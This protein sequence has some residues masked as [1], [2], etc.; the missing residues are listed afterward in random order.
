MENDLLF[1]LRA[2]Y[3]QLFFVILHGIYVLMTQL[4]TIILAAVMTWTVESKSSVS[5]EGT[6]PYDIEVAYNNTYSKGTVRG[7]DDAV[8]T[9]GHLEGITIERV[10][11]YV[12]S[13]KTAGAGTFNDLANGTNICG[14]SGTFKEW[15]GQYDNDSFHAILLYS[16]SKTGVNELVVSLHGT[17]NSLYIEKYVIRYTMGPPGTVTLMHGD[18]VYQ[19]LAEEHSGAGVL[20]PSVPDTAQ[21]TFVGWSSTLF[22]QTTDIPTVRNAYEMYYPHGD[23]V[24]W[25]VFRHVDTPEQV[26]V[27]DL[28]S[29]DYLYVNRDNN[30]A[31]TGVPSGGKMTALKVDMA[32]EAQVYSI[33]FAG[34]DTA[35]IT[36][37]ATGVP[38]GY[39]ETQ[40]ATN[41]SPWLVYHAGEETIFY[42]VIKGKKYVLWLNVK[43]LYGNS[44]AGLF[45]AD[46][47]SGSPMSLC[48]PD[49]AEDP[50][51]TCHPEYGVGWQDVQ[52]EPNGAEYIL[53][54]GN[55]ELRIKN[56]RK[57]LKIK[58]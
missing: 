39:S 57:E 29:G 23:E 17:E 47:I 2:F 35:Y 52:A 22:S 24:L 40:M 8:L 28:E 11:V 30:N 14:K 41:A 19:Q 38:I 54:L 16:G 27:S 1:F 44:Y 7:G 48:Y 34:T 15:T 10:E 43:D 33:D 31:L 12:K 4:L 55:Y 25:A 13:N 18:R 32:N 50:V 42:T 5:G 37:R 53:R 36:H 56:R 46:V 6:W 21:W 45:Q 9:L 20:L 58:N 26:Y 3:F 49:P 51:Y